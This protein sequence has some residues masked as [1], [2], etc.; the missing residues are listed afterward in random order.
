MASLPETEALYDWGGGRVWLRDASET[1]GAAIRDAVARIGGHA[2]RL[3][4]TGDLP[5][6]PPANP[7]V[8]RLEQR[9]KS[10]FDPRGLLNP[11]LMD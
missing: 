9:L 6:F 5:A 4:G 11:G 8:A 2:T 7:V 1:M 10:R 3:R